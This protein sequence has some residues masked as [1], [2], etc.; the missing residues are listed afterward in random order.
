MNPQQLIQYTES[1]FKENKIDILTR[2]MVKEIKEQSVVVLNDK[3]ETV[4]IPFGV[5]VWAAVGFFLSFF[6]LLSLLVPL[7]A[8]SHGRRGGRTWNVGVTDIEC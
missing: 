6:G 8:H 4:E 3:K 1:T 7:V 2:T 5:L